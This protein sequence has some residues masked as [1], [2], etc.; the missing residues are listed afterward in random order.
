MAKKKNLP[1]EVAF[2][3]EKPNQVVEYEDKSHEDF[4]HGALFST[5][6]NEFYLIK[7]VNGRFMKS[8]LIIEVDEDGNP[9][10][11]EEM[12][13]FEPSERFARKYHRILN[14]L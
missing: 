12:G 11:C 14:S 5:E 8:E 7:V 4:L 9:D 10:I 1:A 3:V 2:K 6:D 13:Q